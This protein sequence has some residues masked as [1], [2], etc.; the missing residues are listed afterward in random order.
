MPQTVVGAIIVDSLARPSYVVAAR[1][2]KP[3]ELA[4]RWEFPGGK[5]EVGE[6]PASALEREIR[7]ELGV[8]ISV[9]A[10]LVGPGGGWPI[11][12]VY[13]LRLYLAAVTSGVLHGS[14]DHDAA[15]PAHRRRARGRRLAAVGSAG[16]PGTPRGDGGFV[17]NRLTAP[18]NS[19]YPA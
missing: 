7:E 1:R 10:E 5:V 18:C 14:E 2:T 3:A 9:G 12:E 4:G 8:E 19:F 15:A 16:D 13:V 17:G 6:T 11:S